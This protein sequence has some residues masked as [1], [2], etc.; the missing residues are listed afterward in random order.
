MRNTA[1]GIVI[2]LSLMVLATVPGA[3]G[4]W[5]LID[6]RDGITLY[7]RQISGQPQAQF[8][9]VCI[10]RRPIEAV[11]SVLSDVGSYPKWFFKCM[12]AKKIP[13]EN[14]SELHF[15]LYVAIDT[16]WPFLDRDVVYK[17]DVA[18]DRASGKVFIQ[19]VASKRPFVQLKRQY[20]RITDSEH[21]WILERVS[22]EL[23]RITFINRTNA[24]G[25][26]ADYLSN[27]GMRDT[28]I[29]SLENLNEIL[30]QSFN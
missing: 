14:S 8:K 4:Q 19:S 23:T 24:E 11:G 22:A 29:H 9:G 7:S 20:V 2:V 5:K 28:T 27:S 15:F 12:E 30:K 17:T 13:T 26:F 25:P 6:D 3:G 10:V 16:P 21:Q 1:K 18:V